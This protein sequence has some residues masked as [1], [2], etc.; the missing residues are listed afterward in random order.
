MTT[1]SNSSRIR[2]KLKGYDSRVIDLSSS[3]II[4]TAVRTGAQV[5]GPVPLPTKTER[6]TV[7]RGPHIDKRS[8][9]TFELRSPTK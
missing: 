5:V 9:E 1:S 6:Y 3:K 4:E 7:I 8:R 2:I